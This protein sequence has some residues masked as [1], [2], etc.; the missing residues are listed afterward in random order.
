MLKL[1]P[2]TAENSGWSCPKGMHPLL[3]KLLQLRGVSSD[4]EARRFMH[5][6]RDALNDPYLLS[7]MGEAVDILRDAI[8]KDERI[9]V[10]GD[11]DVDGVCASAILTLYLKEVGADCGVYLPS[12]HTEGYG[13]NADAVDF[14]SKSYQLL[15]TVDC[16][17]TAFELVD[18]AKSEGMRVIVTDH[19]R[20][21]D[22]LPDC[23]T[24]NPLLNNY[25]F[26]YLC[27]AGVAFQLVAALAGR[28]KAMEYIDLA[29]LATIADIVPLRSENRAIAQM[30]LKKINIS[31]RPGM[32]ALINVCGLEGKVLTEG[33]IAFQLTPRLNASGRMG[34]ARRAY[35]L[36]TG[37]D[38]DNCQALAL[39]LDQENR[40]RK[41]FENAAIAEAEAQLIGFDFTAN[42]CI[43]VRG[44]NWNP[45]VIGL[46]ASR[47]TEKYHCP[48][49]AL[50]ADGEYYTGS[51]RSIE[52]VNIH[53]ALKAVS[54]LLERFG[55]HEM[56]AGLKLK[57]E[58]LSEFTAQ[59]N[60]YMRDNCDPALWIPFQ[61][62]DVCA[63]GQELTVELAR[64][65]KA[66]SP[67]GCGNPE[68]V[69]MT[70]CRVDDAYGVGR[71]KEHLKLNLTTGDGTRLSGIWF[72]HGAEAASL[73]DEVDALYAP[74][75]NE[76][77]GQVNLQAMIRQLVPRRQAF[78]ARGD[79]RRFA[80][81]LPLLCAGFNESPRRDA[82]TLAELKEAF[83]RDFR[84]QLL[85]CPDAFSAQM[86]LSVLGEFAD[87]EIGG[88]PTDPRGFNAL[89][90][91]PSGTIPACYKKIYYA[92]I[93]GCLCSGVTVSDVP[94]SK[95]FSRL[96][97]KDTLRTLFKALRSF[98]ASQNIFANEGEVILSAAEVTG[99]PPET[100]ALGVCV[101]QH[102]GLSA[103]E[104]KDGR[105]TVQVC[106]DKR[107]P[108]EDSLYK[109]LR[110]LN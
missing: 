26:G 48:C 27:G 105:L 23:P 11:Y 57:R 93:P 24:V 33:N 31:A 85:I 75:A 92:G 71:E 96:P 64:E 44:E 43:I 54:P 94:V 9:C 80:A 83:A 35:D 18:R 68:P 62:Y 74:D 30:G 52:G 6:D 88:Y 3:Y 97:D 86:A 36:L 109:A 79:E 16:G 15:V 103:F 20:P 10:Y 55:G 53:E 50:S 8:A 77:M 13:L 47:L 46:A 69:F 22:R 34:D 1:K 66:L 87:V 76:Y 28:E 21:G 58:K 72:R 67:T 98:G 73:P 40:N 108:L 61:E 60:A 91:A 104:R 78:D 107:E 29:A 2:R 95:L 39:E 100:A 5:P 90:V 99:I 63:E 51:C 102:A 110:A 17:I 42:P 106:M 59:L 89:C 14:I 56:A 45:G 41:D 101:L 32:R 7:G 65:I 70:R 37:A 82:I 49:V 38:P 19:H 84:G 12:R 4:E 25:P 81:M